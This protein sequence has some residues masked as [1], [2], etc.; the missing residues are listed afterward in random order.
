[1]HQKTPRDAYR[2]VERHYVPEWLTHR[3]QVANF[4]L[5]DHMIWLLQEAGGFNEILR[6]ERKEIEHF[7]HNAQSLR[8]LLRTPFL[9]I[10]PTLETVE[11]WRGFIDETPTTLAVD[12]LRRKLPPMRAMTRHMV[13]QHNRIFVDLITSVIHMNVLAAP[14][15]GITTELANYLVSVPPYKLRLALR[16]MQGLPLFRWRFNTPTFWYQFTAKTLTDEMVAHH[17]MQTSPIRIGDLPRASG[18]VDLRQPREKNEMYAYAMMAYKCRAS[19]VASLFRLNQNA[20]RQRYFEMHGVSSPCGNIPTSLTW[21]VE[22]PHNR[23]HATIYTWLYRAALDAGANG[24]EALI[25]TNDLYE[26]LFDGGA[27]ISADRGCN[28]TRAMAADTRLAIAP[29]RIC[30]THYVVS[31]NDSKIEMQHSFDCPACNNQLGPKRRVSRPRSENAQ[32]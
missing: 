5:V 6:V 23:L 21:F 31:N 12:E 19:T 13:E 1:M 25:A 8:N 20:M 14:L 9:M 18:W 16:R 3:I 24:P 7:T 17:L 22:T 26:L 28:L 4:D 10:A 29:C 15:L 2:S 32:S 27:V 30:R 11:D